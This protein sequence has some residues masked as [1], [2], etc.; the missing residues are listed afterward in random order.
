MQVLDPS[1]DFADSR[2]WPNGENE[3]SLLQREL[4]TTSESPSSTNFAI[5]SSYAK[6]NTLAATMASTISIEN[7]KRACSNNEAITFP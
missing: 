5:P 7:G 2:R 1:M 6:T 4:I 3:A